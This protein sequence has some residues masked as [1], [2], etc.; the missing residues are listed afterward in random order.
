MINK[1]KNN[2]DTITILIAIHALQGV[3]AN[4]AHPITP[5]YL[6]SLDFP[7]TMFGLVFAAMSFTNFA[8]SPFWGVMSR[9]IKAKKLVLI[10]AFG[11]ALGQAI[12]G[13]SSN[14]YIIIFARLISGVFVSALFV[15]TGLYVVEKSSPEEKGRNITKMLTIFSVFGTIGFF[16]GG[17]IG[18]YSLKIPFIIQIVTLITVGILYYVFLE[19]NE[20]EEKMDFKRIISSSSPIVKSDKPLTKEL[21][22]NF[23]IVFLISIAS[24]SLTQTFSYF[25][26]DALKMTS[27]A[28]GM[29]KGL[30]GLI[31]LIFNFTIALR[32]VRSKDIQKNLIYIFATVILTMLPMI[33]FNQTPYIFMTM[34]VVAMSIDTMPVSLLQGRTVAYSED[35]AQGE[36]VG[37]HNTM[38]ALGMIIGSLVASWIYE[39]NIVSP[40]I[41]SI[42]LYIIGM[43][44]LQRTR[45]Y[46]K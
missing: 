17:Y 28:N 11:Y 26:D 40:F 39:W 21:V 33:G 36:M 19:D 30:V 6:S 35:D 31:S 10:G 37:Y 7:S 46:V 2:V 38:K 44:L 34:G 9:Y 13:F 24:T 41:L 5:A 43:L 16:I 22:M 32:V 23:W 12:F 25:I 29:T 14:P 8:F 45:K 15:G 1:I 18:G 4:F 3:A 27:V 42:L 20:V